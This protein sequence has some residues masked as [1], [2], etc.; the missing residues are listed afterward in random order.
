MKRPRVCEAFEPQRPKPLSCPSGNAGR[1]VLVDRIDGD[2]LAHA[3]A[4]GELDDAGDLGEERVV[5][6][7]AYVGAGLD[8]GA[9]LADDDGAAGD[10]LSAESLDAKP[11]RVR[12]AAVP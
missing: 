5:L 4:V 10:E 3:A 9:A 7:A 6:A 12:I 2:E 1:L 8:A 11:L